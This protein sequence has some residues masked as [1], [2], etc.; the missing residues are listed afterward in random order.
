MAERVT[1]F[2]RLMLNFAPDAVKII[3]D[4]Q[5]TIDR[6]QSENA[7]LVDHIREEHHS[8]CQSNLLDCDCQRR[9]R[10]RE[11]LANLSSAAE[12]SD[13]RLK[14]EGATEAL[15]KCGCSCQGTRNPAQMSA[16]AL[17]AGAAVEIL[18]RCVRCKLLEQAEAEAARLWRT[19]K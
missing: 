19:G 13:K 15:R 11:L 9:H 12:A 14:A 8:S 6:L 10:Q 5:C 18:V 1:E 3:R 7:A 2:E 16:E 4:Q 17:E